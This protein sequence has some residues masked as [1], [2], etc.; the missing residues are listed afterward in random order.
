MTAAVAAVV[1]CGRAF[2]SGATACVVGDVGADV[3]GRRVP[4]VAVL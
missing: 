1:R 4:S 2:S 3:T